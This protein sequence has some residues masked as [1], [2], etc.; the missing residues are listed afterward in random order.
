MVNIDLTN[1]NNCEKNQS[2]YVSIFV[3]WR[4][5]TGLCYYVATMLYYE[6]WNFNSDNYLFTTDTK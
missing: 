2:G 6:G 1:R 4:N 5:G 3:N